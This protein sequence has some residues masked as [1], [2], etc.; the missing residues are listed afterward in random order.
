MKMNSAVKLF[1]LYFIKASSAFPIYG[2][3]IPNG[4][5]VPNP[6]PQGGVWAGVGH[7]NAA[8]GGQRNQFGLDFKDSG[9][10]WTEALCKMDSDGDGRSNGEELGDPQCIWQPG[11]TPAM[12]ALSHPG[13]QDTPLTNQAETA[14]SYCDDYEDPA[15]VEVLD[16]VFSQPN[17]LNSTRTHYRCEQ[18]TVDAP[19]GITDQFQVRTDVILSNPNVLHH[20]WI[21]HC[22]SGLDS[23]DGMKVGQGSYDCNGVE[24]NCQIIAGWAVGPEEYCEPPNVAAYVDFAASNVFKIEAHYDNA[25]RVDNV[26]DQ[27]GMSLR[28]TPTPR[29]LHAGLSILGMSYYD[30]RFTVPARQKAHSLVNLC[31]TDATLRGL[32]RP[33]YVYSWNPHMHLY[34]TKL[35]T[36][37]YRC[38]QKIG[39]IGR[40]EQFEFDNQQSYMLNPPVK[41]L[42]GD[43][44]VTSC[45]YDS[46]DVQVD[47]EG[48]EET[49][50][51]MCDNYLTYYPNVGTYLEPTLFS[52]CQSYDEGLNPSSVGY[53]DSTPFLTLDLAGDIFMQNWNPDVSQNIAPCCATN[54]CESDFLAKQ[55]SPCAVTSDCATGLVCD[56]GICKAET[57]QEPSDGPAPNRND[58]NAEIMAEDSSMATEGNDAVE[59]S[60]VE[61]STE[62]NETDNSASLPIVPKLMIFVITIMAT[63][64]IF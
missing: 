50:Q 49:T 43:A 18:L 37:H 48:G 61:D 34:G 7:E 40:I 8:G 12:H 39:E 47:I 26:Q 9:F 58:A 10:E 3:R 54:S 44:L 51:E 16:I 21:Y 15:D 64:S 31:P 33:I 56:G 59:G 45:T 57:T 4:R 38:G 53:D 14:P 52:A 62:V 13:I 46:S 60:M 27:S 17:T 55:W 32:N 19:L 25:A 35:V 29:N 11:G 28:L 20:I 41:V 6:G 36:E 63:V 24:T 42:P 30:R 22:S 2:D 1:C 5:S 23:S